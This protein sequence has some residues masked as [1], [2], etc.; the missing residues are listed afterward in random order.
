MIEV[1]CGLLGYFWMMVELEVVLV[2]AKGHLG[3]WTL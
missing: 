3:D 2:N 1:G